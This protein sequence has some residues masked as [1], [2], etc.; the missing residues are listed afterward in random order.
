MG[1]RRRYLEP[2][3]CEITGLGPRATGLGTAPDGKPIRVKGAAP[4]TR[5][6]VRVTG[7]KRGVWSGRRERTIRRPASGS[8]PRC[9]IFDL[10]GGCQ[11]QEIDPDA[12]RLAKEAF[13]LAEIGVGLELTEAQVRERFTV[14]P[15]REASAPW[16][17]RNKVE[18]SFGSSR[19]L[20]EADHAAGLPI[21][22][23]FLGFHAP[24]RFDR[25]VDAE[26]C[27]L[28]DEPANAIVAAVRRHALAE[29]AP[30]P[31]NTREHTGFWRHLVLRQGQRTGERVVLLI[32]A[33]DTF[34]AEPTVE[35]LAT[36]LLALDEVIGVQWRVNGGVADV[37]RGEVFR[38]WG[39]VEWTERL[40]S[41]TFQLRPEAFFQT[42]TPGAEVLYD[43]VGEA[44]GQS[45]G[46][47]LDLYCGIG[48]IG[49]YLSDRYDRI[50]GIEEVEGAVL[51]ARKNAEANGVD[52][53][54]R[55][56]K[57]EAALEAI[58]G[59]ES[60]D[61]VVDPPRA[62]LHP[63]VAKTLASTRARSLVYVACNP[64]SL[65]RDAALMAEGW[66]LVELWTVD[67]FPHT[68]HVEAVGRFERAG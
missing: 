24:G 9:A 5:V 11:L 65:G 46:T 39:R 6:L 68:G 50:E 44:L 16:G 47:L 3:E 26:R 18:L 62:G 41:V 57:V 28:I 12:Q 67:L 54:W 33:P 1:R 66:R 43:C 37:A 64:A 15:I 49:L 20:S 52:G 25:V 2:F 32:T 58:R 8:E 59:G 14:H 48:S 38:T 7:R 23:R 35:A 60:V 31:W 19:Y 42:S 13:A 10:C 30:P 63:K 34:E 22:G 29:T 4:G 51:D 55:S 61:L 40:G 36:E 27:E 53:T 21:D 45:G 17:Y 56:D